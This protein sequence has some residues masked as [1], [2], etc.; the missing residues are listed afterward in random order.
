MDLN[1]VTVSCTDYDRSVEF[2]QKL[3]LRL[4]VNSPPRYGRFETPA[5]STFSI[6]DGS[7]PVSETV[8]YFEVEDVDA[9]FERLKT[10]GIEFETEPTDQDWLWR[11]V[12]LC[13][14]A[15]NR[16]CLYHAGENRRFPAWRI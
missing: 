2:Y 3:G 14:P 1:Q 5:G 7:T 13:D 4:I 11:E 8:I 12:Y 16:L 6:H 10:L 9:E 15:G